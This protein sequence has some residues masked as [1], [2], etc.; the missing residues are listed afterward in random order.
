MPDA[1]TTTMKHKKPSTIIEQ[2][3]PPNKRPRK[4]SSAADNLPNS[5]STAPE[6]SNED[7]GEP[8]DTTEA[9]TDIASRSKLKAPKPSL[10]VKSQED[11]K[12]DESSTANRTGKAM[13][14]PPKA[15]LIA[16]KGYHINPPPKDRPVRVYA[17]GVFDLFHLGYD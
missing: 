12:D 4:S 15:G 9:S 3:N 7:P 16:P 17:D 8:S 1:L 2:A 11:Q 5:G 14:P 13:P 10:A 6:I